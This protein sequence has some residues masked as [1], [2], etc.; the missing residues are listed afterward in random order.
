M[1]SQFLCMWARV[2][3]S[4]L[5]HLMCVVLTVAMLVLGVTAQD[6]Q[7]G[8]SVVYSHGTGTGNRDG[9]GVRG[10]VYV[11]VSETWKVLGEMSWV[12]EPKA[13]LNDSTNT[14]RAR[15]DVRAQWPSE[16]NWRPFVS[17]GVSGVHQRTSLF[18]K[19]AFNPTVGA[20]VNIG[21][22][23]VPYWRHYFTERQTQNRANADEIGGE[24]YMPISARLVVR[25]GVAGVN[26]RFT[27]PVGHPNEGRH[28][29]WTLVTHGGVGFVF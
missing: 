24:M 25:A 4:L 29:V 13:Y 3:A 10:E 1:T 19:S 14:L 2:S 20:G 28:S 7:A 5:L 11:P 8:V 18:T 16:G 17:A 9:V 23:L 15:L 26:T 12:I 21:Q 27:Q 22:V 6:R